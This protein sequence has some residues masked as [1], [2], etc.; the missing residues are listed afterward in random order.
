MPVRISNLSAREIFRNR[1]TFV[2]SNSITVE[3]ID[4]ALMVIDQ[5]DFDLKV[6]LI[7][8]LDALDASDGDRSKVWDDASVS[9]AVM[10]VN[11]LI[12]GHRP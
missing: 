2:T 7:E 9:H 12:A 3:L 8:A 11:A 10:V 4:A 6:R 1:T 5:S